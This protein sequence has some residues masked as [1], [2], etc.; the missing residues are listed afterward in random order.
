MML[1]AQEYDIRKATEIEKQKVE[2][3]RD[4]A[5]NAEGIDRNLIK[6]QSHAFAFKPGVSFFRNPVLFVMK[7]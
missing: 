3:D 7:E 1:K 5:V 4:L 2:D 6:G